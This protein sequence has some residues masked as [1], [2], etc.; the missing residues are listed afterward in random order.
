MIITQL[1]QLVHIDEKMVSGLLDGFMLITVVIKSMASKMMVP[2]R[3]REK[4]VQCTR[5]L[6]ML[7]CQ[8]TEGHSSSCSSSSDSLRRKSKASSLLQ[9]V[10]R[11]QASLQFCRHLRRS[12]LKTLCRSILAQ[13]CQDVLLQA[14]AF[15]R[16]ASMFQVHL[17]LRIRVRQQH[18]SILTEETRVPSSTQ[19]F[20][21]QIG[22]VTSFRGHWE[23]LGVLCQAYLLFLLWTLEEFKTLEPFFIPHLENNCWVPL[24]WQSKLSSWILENIIEREPKIII[25]NP[26]SISQINRAFMIWH[27]STLLTSSLITVLHSSPYSHAQQSHHI[28]SLPSVFWTCCFLQLGRLFPPCH[29]W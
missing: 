23:S 8:P 13:M 19:P 22:P 12:A 24:Y 6:H 25:M 17:A 29:L 14:R 11:Y 26:W 2:M 10:K 3:W 28:Y 16:A 18:C 1:Q 4:M 5:G 21:S 7:N 15:V 27:L 9:K 20:S